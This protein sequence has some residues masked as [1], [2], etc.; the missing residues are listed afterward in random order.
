MTDYFRQKKI[1]ER[2]AAKKD[3][4]KRRDELNEREA[5]IKLETEKLE[6][7]SYFQHTAAVC[8]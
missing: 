7:V 6:S 5:Q 2:L 3:R 4:R 1:R 8:F